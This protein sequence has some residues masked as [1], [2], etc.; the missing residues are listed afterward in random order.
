MLMNSKRIAVSMENVGSESE[1]S[2][3]A[4]GTP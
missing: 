2:E 4:G 1:T 3:V